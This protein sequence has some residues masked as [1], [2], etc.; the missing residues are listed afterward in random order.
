M[1]STKTGI[2]TAIEAQQRDEHRVSVFLDGKF[3]L[4]LFADV[5]VTLGLRVGQSITAERLTEITDLETRRKALED[6][7]GF[8]SFRARSEKEIRDKLQRKGYEEDV[9]DAVIARLSENNFV[10]DAEFAAQWTRHRQT[11]KGRRFI[12]QELR[13]KGVDADTIQETLAESVT[14]EGESETAYTLAVRR[15]GTTPADKSRE[16]QAK[17]A[18][19]LQRRGFGWDIVRGVLRRLYDVVPGEAEE[20]LS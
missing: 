15:V 16:A 20:H 9:T 2:I 6:A 12:A 11:G 7:Y 19:F 18:A 8:L 5:A 3:A 17:L 13:Q 1:V 14:D 4:G 10:N